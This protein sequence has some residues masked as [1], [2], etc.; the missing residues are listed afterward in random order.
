M[1][2]TPKKPQPPAA[3]T[4]AA[5]RRHV[6]RRE[7]ERRRQRMVV[8]VSSAAVG[9]ALLA[10]LAGVLYEQ[11]W[12][13]S[14]PVAQ[15]GSATLTRGDYERERRAETARTIG[16]SLYLATFGEQFAQQ[17][18]GQIGQLDAEVPQI[19]SQPLNELTI[20]EW[21]E[22]QIIAQRASSEFGIQATDAEIAQALVV[23]YGPAFAPTTSVTPTVAALPTLPP[24]TPEEGTPAAAAEGDAEQTAA[25]ADTATSAPTESPAPTAT[26]AGPTATPSPTATPEPTTPPTPTPQAEEALRRQGE[27]IT[28]MF[29]DYRTQIQLID[30]QRRPQLTEEDFRNGLIAQFQRQVLVEKIQERLVPEGSFTPSTDPSNIETRHI[31]IKVTVPLTATE[32]EREAAYAERRAEAEE[33]LEQALGGADFAALAQEHSEDYNTRAEGG[34]LPGFDHTGRTLSGTQIDPAIV[35][36]VADLEEGQV[37]PELVRTS[38]GWHV[39]QLV[40]RTVD[41]PE[42][43]LRRKRTEE[44][45]KWLEAQRNVLTVQRFPA[46][47]PTPTPLPTSTPEPLPTLEL[48][49]NPSPTPLPTPS[50]IPGEEDETIEEATPTPGGT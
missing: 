46:V 6:T 10:V 28:R 16:Q 3:R 31:L 50:P 48:G 40:S 18:L 32:E 26:P 34:T 30:P 41:S 35:E 14:R 43:Q 29:N 38:F 8:I 15:V 17:F 2:Q 45:D 11:V 36:A 9:L 39:V 33:L 4:A 27:V 20:N 25:P 42:D 22:R 12:V 37:A 13:P 47:S 24:L 7:R 5:T 44:F 1:S 21:A 23:D 49:G 19:R